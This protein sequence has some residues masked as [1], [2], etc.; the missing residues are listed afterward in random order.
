MPRPSGSIFIV[1][2]GKGTMDDEEIKQGKIY[3]VGAN[4]VHSLEV[5][6]STDETLV[7]FQTF[8]NV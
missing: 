8:A 4:E 6:P 2:H 3:F 1:L 5:P 7:L